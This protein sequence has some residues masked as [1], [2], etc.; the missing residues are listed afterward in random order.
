MFT[1]LLLLFAFAGFAAD[2]AAASFSRGAMAKAAEEMLANAAV[3][4]EGSRELAGR[5]FK[6]ACMNLL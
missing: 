1:L 4:A 6:R 5:V 2:R 3:A